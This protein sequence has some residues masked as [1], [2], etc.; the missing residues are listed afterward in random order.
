MLTQRIKPLENVIIIITRMEST[1]LAHCDTL[2][3]GR[4]QVSLATRIYNKSYIIHGTAVKVAE[5]HIVS[6]F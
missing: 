1:E 3:I 4:S 6:I 2:I 5:S